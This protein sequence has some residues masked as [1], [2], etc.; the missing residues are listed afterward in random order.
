M[1]LEENKMM[2]SAFIYATKLEWKVLPLHWVE[3]GQCSCKGKKVN[4]K[5]GKHPLTKNGVKDA[6][7]DTSII[8]KWWTKWPK[9]NIGIACGEASG[10]IV[11][12]VDLKKNVDGHD[13]VRELEKSFEVLPHTPVQLSGSGGIHYFFKCNSNIKNG[14]EFLPGLDLRS[15]G[16][17][18]IG[19]PSSHISGKEYTWELEH[20]VLETSIQ[21]A[22]YW[23][24]QTI[25]NNT[26]H[27]Y[28]KKPASH[29]VNLLQ[30]VGE[31]M[32]NHST[33]S[34]IGYLLRK[35]VDADITYELIKIWN[36]T[37]CNPSQSMEELN[38][39][40][41]SI[42]KKDIERKKGSDKYEGVG[43]R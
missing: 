15:D 11:L 8:K 27:K 28:D 16:G 7:F 6:T 34:L 25:I 2:K 23:L 14:V 12:D 43:S 33:A 10:I 24:V 38:K 35:N 37:R 17:Y 41:V 36:E 31:G 4:C 20:H 39:T 1:V 22:P 26:G 13:T 5:P 9:A 21:E 18:I 32:R 42:L 3:N 30:G 29:Y 40:F 19:A